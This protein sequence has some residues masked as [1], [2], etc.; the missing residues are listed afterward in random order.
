MCV[1]VVG[2]GGGTPP[3]YLV[4]GAGG[5]ECVWVSSVP[6]GARPRPT[7]G[8]AR[9]GMNVCGCRRYRRGHAPALLLQGFQCCGV[10]GLAGDFVD[11]VAVDDAAVFVEDED[12]SGEEPCEGSV[13]E[14]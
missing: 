5:C 12:A 7:L 10:V 2:T 3:P 8:L 6:A 9:G 1:G 13:N 4:V 14:L 11:E